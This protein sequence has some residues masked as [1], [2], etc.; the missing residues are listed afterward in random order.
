MIT[1]ILLVL[2]AGW[3]LSSI[4]ALFFV[5]KTFKRYK[6][7]PRMEVP[8]NMHATIRQDFG[9]WDEAAI[10]KGCLL[11]FPLHFFLMSTFLA[12][13]GI[14]IILQKYLKFPP[15]II[16]LFRS[17]IGRLASTIN[18]HLVEDFDPK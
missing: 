15:F 12:S 9:R 5:K 16:E 11:R 2:A 10:I 18:W 17:K 14:L 3:L 6:N 1:T 8:E 13:Y 4:V 7:Y